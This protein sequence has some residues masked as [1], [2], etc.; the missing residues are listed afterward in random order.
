M[1]RKL[2]V[3]FDDHDFEQIALL[4]KLNK[5]KPTDI[6]RRAMQA[7]LDR[8]SVKFRRSEEDGE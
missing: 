1:S 4:A 3:T 6:V 2:A 7:Y 8:G 5:T